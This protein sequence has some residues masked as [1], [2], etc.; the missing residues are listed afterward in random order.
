MSRKNIF[1]L[2]VVALTLFAASLANWLVFGAT[3][4]ARSYFLWHVGFPNAWRK[5]NL[6]PLVISAVAAVN[7]HGRDEFA[8]LIAFTIQWALVGLAFSF[9]LLLFREL[10]PKR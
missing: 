4:P 7:V 3:S 8:F 9:F 1:H 5:L 6:I 10:L 2:T